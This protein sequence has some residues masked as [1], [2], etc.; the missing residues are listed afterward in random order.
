M[1]IQARR[2]GE[3]QHVI[4][5]SLSVNISILLCVEGAGVT[6]GKEKI[7]EC[8]TKSHRGICG[9]QEHRELSDRVVLKSGY[10]SCK[11]FREMVPVCLYTAV[12]HVNKVP[13]KNRNQVPNMRTPV[14]GWK[15]LTD[16]AE[17]PL[18][19]VP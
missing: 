14:R 12:Y 4:L 5:L 18:L 10:L 19:L 11:G 9:S 2:Q 13:I 6:E 1:D 17:K 3:L 8:E 7:G 15:R 16:K